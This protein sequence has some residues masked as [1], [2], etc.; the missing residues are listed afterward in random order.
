[1]FE[2]G[3]IV[4]VF[5]ILT[6]KKESIAMGKNHRNLLSAST[7]IG[8]KVVNL[9][10]ENI[11]KIEDL[12]IVL[13]DG[14][15]GYA[16]LSFGGILGIGDKLFAIPWA[17]LRIDQEK[18]CFVMDVDKDKL[19]NAPGF[20]K[21]NWPDMEDEAWGVAVHSYYNQKPYWTTQL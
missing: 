6:T 12:M 11:G 8:D 5:L 18:E 17:S 16:V 21:D 9:K 2:V 20:D 19:D 13:K 7:L 15:V 3:H 4:Y 10:N 14:R 1:V